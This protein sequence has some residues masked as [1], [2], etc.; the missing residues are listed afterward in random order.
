MFSDDLAHEAR[1]DEKLHWIQDG[2]DRDYDEAR[3]REQ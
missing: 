2:R 1:Q 3:E